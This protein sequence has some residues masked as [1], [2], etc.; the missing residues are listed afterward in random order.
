MINASLVFV[1]KNE[2]VRVAEIL[3]QMNLSLFAEVY[4]IDGNSQDQ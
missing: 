3:P 2:E 4:A 1:T